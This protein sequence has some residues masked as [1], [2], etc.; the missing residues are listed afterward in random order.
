M[1]LPENWLQGTSN[2][3]VH[4]DRN[5]LQQMPE[6]QLPAHQFALMRKQC[7]SSKQTSNWLTSRQTSYRNRCT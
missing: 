3:A 5:H 2:P 4:K 6:Q 7:L 1:P